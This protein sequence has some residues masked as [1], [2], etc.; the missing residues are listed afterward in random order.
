[1]DGTSCAER[2]GPGGGSGSAAVMEVHH[3][4]P[5]LTGGVE[6]FGRQ[7]QRS[8]GQRRVKWIG[9]WR[10]RIDAQLHPARRIRPALSRF[11]HPVKSHLRSARIIDPNPWALA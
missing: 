8:R 3:W 6:S 7:G 4:N 5:R 2:E 1:M 9:G 10:T 11:W